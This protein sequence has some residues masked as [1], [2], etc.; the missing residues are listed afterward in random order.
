MSTHCTLKL[1][2]YL[3][4]AQVGKLDDCE[5]ALLF[6]LLQPEPLQLGKVYGIMENHYK[7]ARGSSTTIL[8]LIVELDW[9]ERSLRMEHL[10]AE[11]IESSLEWTGKKI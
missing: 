1:T 5:G 4:I 2:P 8:D 9:T 7:L 11:L 6:F 10:I 3:L